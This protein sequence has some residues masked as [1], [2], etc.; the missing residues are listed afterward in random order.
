[1]YEAMSLSVQ[2]LPNH[3]STRLLTLAPSPDLEAPVTGRLSVIDLADPSSLTVP[4]EAI[5][6]TWGEFIKNEQHAITID[7][8]VVLVRTNLYNALRRLRHPAQPRTLWCDFLCISQTDL[9]EKE[10]QVRM[11]GQIF[12]SAE[13]VLVWLGEHADG[14]EKLFDTR[15]WR[16]P[17]GQQHG[18]R[19]DWKQ[20]LLDIKSETEIT[21]EASRARIWADLFLRAYVSSLSLRV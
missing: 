10:Q 9:R 8:Q 16:C 13:R 5:S 18:A 20:K 14:S 6:Y 19:R 1:M 11:I 7:D 17:P 2:G 15:D 4:Y 21:Q 12:A 3:T